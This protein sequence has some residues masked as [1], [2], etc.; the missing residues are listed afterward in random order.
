[1]WEPIEMTGDPDSLKRSPRVSIQWARDQIK[2]YGRNSPWVKVNVFGEFPEA[3]LNTLLGPD[4]VTAAMNRRLDPGV[5]EWA[6]KR[7]GVDVSRF[8]DDPTI[9]FPRQGLC[10]FRPVMMMHERDSAVSVN[11][12]SRVMMA[13]A[14]W[15]GEMEFFDAT[16]GWAAGARDIMVAAGHSPVSIIYNTP[17]LDNSFLNRRAEMWMNGSSWVKN[18][19]ALPNVPELV[20]EMCTPM[21][22]YVGGKF[23]IEPKDLVKE[24][25]GRSPNY[26]DAL[27]NTFA[28]PDM[29][30]SGSALGRLM[31]KNSR[32]AS[33]D[34]NP[35][36]DEISR[37]A[38]IDYDPYSDDR[39]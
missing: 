9:I 26:A 25:L 21:Y 29:P 11:I 2:K 12:A 6:Q 23:Q 37:N 34:F 10:A 8:G 30:G 38:R 4:E 28:I 17:A 15:G 3:S 19:G 32:H 16:G 20:A 24:R 31:E 39:I 18:G 13:K 14:R 1:M 22:T 36:E 5:Y 33:T 27:Y 35:F 7:L